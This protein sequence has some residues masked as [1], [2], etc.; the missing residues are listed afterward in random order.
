[1]QDPLD[2]GSEPL[3]P[4][5]AI[6]LGSPTP[7]GSFLRARLVTPL[8]SATTQKGGLVAAVVSRPLFNE[9]HLILPQ[10][11]RLKGS[12][13]QVQ[14]A[15]YMSRNGQLR[16]VFHEL[17]PPDGPGG[18]AMAQKVDASLESVQSGKVESVELDS[19]G[20]AKATTPKTR[21][22]TPSYRRDSPPA[23]K[24]VGSA[25]WDYPI[26]S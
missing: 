16:V 4:E 6:S 2:F 25:T 20:G 18:V 5:M 24:A 22:L 13:V 1:M 21:Y 15:R 3:T 26:P 23:I 17:I 14:P 19:E 8:N 11:S 10:G 12:V 7:A 9:K